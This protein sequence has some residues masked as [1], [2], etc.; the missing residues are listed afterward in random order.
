MTLAQAAGV[1]CLSA[2]SW[3]APCWSGDSLL[4]TYF[5][6]QTGSSEPDLLSIGFG[7]GGSECTLT[8][9]ATS[10]PLGTEI[11]SVLTFEPAL[12]AG[13]TVTIKVDLRRRGGVDLRN[14]VTVEEPAPCLYGTMTPAEAG[15]YRVE[16]TITPS[17]MPPLVGEFDVNP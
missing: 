10:F 5:L 8:E 12:P 15:H 4:A 17:V 13:G 16:Y 7:T 3:S 2:P 1:C 11:R 9:Q 14:S 6:D